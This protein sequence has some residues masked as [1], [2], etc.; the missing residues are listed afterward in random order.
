MSDDRWHK[1]EK[2]NKRLVS[3]SP[4]SKKTFKHKVNFD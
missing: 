4:E 1:K 2:K 3:S